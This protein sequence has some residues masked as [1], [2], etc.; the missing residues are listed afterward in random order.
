MCHPNG[1]VGVLQQGLLPQR[2][3]P[4][5]LRDL[6]SYSLCREA[7]RTRQVHRLPG[8]AAAK[9]LPPQMCPICPKDHPLNKAEDGLTVA[10]KGSMQPAPDGERQ[11]WSDSLGGLYGHFLRRS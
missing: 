9:R 1:G 7:A 6:K 8:A 2:G 4:R 11:G 5:L 10:E 3:C